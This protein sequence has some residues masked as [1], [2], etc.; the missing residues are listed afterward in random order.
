MRKNKK[1]LQEELDRLKVLMEVYLI[2]ES[3]LVFKELSDLILR[4]A[5]NLPDIKMKYSKIFGDL[6]NAKNDEEAIAALAKLADVNPS[7][8]NV[9]ISKVMST[10]K[11]E[12]LQFVD[13]LIAHGKKLLQEK[14]EKGNPKHTLDSVKK[15]I[16]SLVDNR[17]NTEFQGV[18]DIIKK[19]VIDAITKPVKV[20]DDTTPEGKLSK[21]IEDWDIITSRGLSAKDKI[22]LTDK[23]WFRG[24]RAKINYILNNAYNTQIKRLGIDGGQSKSLEKIIGLIKQI[25]S[26]KKFFETKPQIFAAIDA[27]IEA[28]RQTEYFTKSEIYN[29]I[30]DAVETK[31][32][33][34][35]GYDFVEKLKKN[36]KLSE[37]YPSYYKYLTDESALGKMLRFPGKNETIFNPSPWMIWWGNFIQRTLMF[38]STSTIYK[39]NEIFNSY[40]RKHGVALGSLYFAATSKVI[41]STIVPILYALYDSLYHGITTDEQGIGFWERYKLFV[42]ERFKE[43]A[44]GLERDIDQQ[45]KNSLDEEQY[46][47]WKALNPFTTFWDEIGTGLDWFESGGFKRW[48]D[49]TE[50]RNQEII[51]R[52]MRRINNIPNIQRPQ[53]PSVRINPQQPNITTPNPQPAPGGPPGGPPSI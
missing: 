44:L 18:K 41:K 12:V 17:I 10:R 46:N 40:V 33:R 13:D 37:D 6:A 39:I 53:I 49:E 24:L 11:A 30:Q 9:I 51:D 27:E 28:L 31:L 19:D 2:N 45:A 36:D 43:F 22:L 48:A 4:A 26:D 16:E 52:E 42:I 34:G 21:L 38:I 20:I 7:F 14:D 1:N 35:R 32:G 15:T 8:R 3:V 25:D 5:D 29:V 23:L 47:I 50:R